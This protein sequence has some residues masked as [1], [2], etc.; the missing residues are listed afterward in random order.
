[1]SVAPPLSTLDWTGNDVP[2]GAG[3]SF[4]ITVLEFFI[5]FNQLTYD[6][7]AYLLNS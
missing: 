3:V 7:G 1:M 5:V 2:Q 4:F 6:I